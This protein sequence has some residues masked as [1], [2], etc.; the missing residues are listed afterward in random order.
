ML[1]LLQTGL[2]AGLLSALVSMIIS[3]W[4]MFILAALFLERK[5][6]LV[7]GSQ[8][9]VGKHL[10]NMLACI[11]EATINGLLTRSLKDNHYKYDFAWFV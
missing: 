8:T 6:D 5:R 9:A 4:T 3:A 7:R 1:S 10:D 11:A 2:I